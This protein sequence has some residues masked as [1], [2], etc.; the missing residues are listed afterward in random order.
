LQ[1][2]FDLAPAVAEVK[3]HYEGPVTIG[4]DLQCTPVH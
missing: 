2:E 1:A 4:E 3:K